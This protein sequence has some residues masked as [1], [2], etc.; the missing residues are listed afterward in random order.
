LLKKTRKPA[1]HGFLHFI[2]LNDT[3]PDFLVNFFSCKE[4]LANGTTKTF[5]WITD[6][7]ITESNVYDLMRGG[8]TR[9]KIENETFNTLKNQGYEF[10]HNFGHGN[11]N[12]SVVFATLM[13]LA[14]AIDQL[15]Q[16]SCSY[17]Q[18]ALTKSGSRA[19]LWKELQALVKTYYVNSWTDLFEAITFGHKG[20][21]L[22]PDTS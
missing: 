13:F 7:K 19:A 5:T 22:T 14:F 12:L 8:R 6:L 18:A 10:E 16:I 4:T 20:A 21:K 17:F 3:H 11:K 1:N 15:Q 2:T 9:W